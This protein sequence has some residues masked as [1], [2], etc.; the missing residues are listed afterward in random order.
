MACQNK[1]C[2][3][4]SSLCNKTATKICYGQT[5]KDKT[6]YPSLI[7]S[8]G[9]KKIQTYTLQSALRDFLNIVV[10]MLHILVLHYHACQSLRFI[11]F[12]VTYRYIFWRVTI[13]YF[14]E[15]KII[16]QKRSTC[17]FSHAT[18]LLIFVQSIILWLYHLRKLIDCKLANACRNSAKHVNTITKTEIVEILL[19]LTKQIYTSFHR[20]KP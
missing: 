17:C 7:R 19:R 14:L 16:V 3:K 4:I 9:N 10:F 20:I 13:L 1:E 6:V 11:I 18:G 15:K 8:G 12:Q 5:H 2:A